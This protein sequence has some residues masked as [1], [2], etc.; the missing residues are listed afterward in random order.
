MTLRCFVAMAFD[1]DDT[2]K[3]Y[4]RVIKPLLERRDVVAFRVDRSNRNDDIDDQ[5]LSEL[6]Q[7]DFVISDLTYARP[8]VYFE[9]GVAHGRAI[10]VIYTCRKDH[11]LPKADDVHGNCRVHF[12][13]QMKP[14]IRWDDPVGEGFARRLENRIAG[15]TRPIILRR[16]QS[17]TLETAR[18]IFS[19]LSLEERLKRIQALYRKCF[20]ANGFRHVHSS[21]EPSRWSG[22]QNGSALFLST[23][24]SARTLTKKELEWIPSFCL[25]PNIELFLKHGSFPRSIEQHV[26]VSSLVPVPASRV[27]AAMPK[28]RVIRRT[29]E[30][31]A[32]E[33]EVL[34]KEY[35]SRHGRARSRNGRTCR[36]LLRR[37]FHVVSGIS[38]E[39]EFKGRMDDIL[40]VL[41]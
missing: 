38:S 34:T 23:G 14:I 13:L 16:K 32:V 39:M 21:G 18:Q 20:R 5:I 28:Y 22:K 9:A 33:A 11:F 36:F 1:R 8:S 30:V 26:F 24:Y 29:N 35:F 27:A 41:D 25:L 2:D 3:L 12:D 40:Q 4:D 6:Q 7:S 37:H 15:V 31:I 19:G 10:P 17:H